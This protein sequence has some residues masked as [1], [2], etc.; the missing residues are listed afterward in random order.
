MIITVRGREYAVEAEDYDFQRIRN[1]E[2]REL[3][4]KL[5]MNL[6]S[7]APALDDAEPDALAFVAWTM[8]RQAGHAGIPFNADDI[9]FELGE[10]LEVISSE[11][12]VEAEPDPTQTSSSPTD[13]AESPAPS[14][15]RAGTGRRPAGPPATPSSTGSSPG[16]SSS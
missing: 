13:S 4:R 10:L 5:G 9:D 14:T 3:K 7:L 1:E 8:L 6:G 2:L 16:T 12:E 15:R 11:E